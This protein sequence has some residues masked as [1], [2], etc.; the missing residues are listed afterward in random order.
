MIDLFRRQAVERQ[1]IKLHST[2]NA[3]NSFQTLY[4][5]NAATRGQKLIIS[6]LPKRQKRPDCPFATHHSTAEKKR[7]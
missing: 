7:R 1:N 5:E 3:Q 6:L 2:K 4:Q